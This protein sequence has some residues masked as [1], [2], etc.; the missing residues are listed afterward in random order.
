[1][2]TY[3]KLIQKGQWSTEVIVVFSFSHKC[4]YQIKCI[5]LPKA[6]KTGTGL[7]YIKKMETIME[8]FDRFLTLPSKSYL[9]CHTL[10]SF[11]GQ[12]NN[13]SKPQTPVIK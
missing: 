7:K 8:L 2:K 1:V 12:Y 4:K 10:N 11:K 5:T 3:N 6:F 13:Y 9:S